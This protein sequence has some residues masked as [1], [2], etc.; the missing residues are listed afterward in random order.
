MQNL[1]RWTIFHE[2][3]V[4]GEY[5]T[6][7]FVLQEL[8]EKVIIHNSNPNTSFFNCTWYQKDLTPILL[9]DVPKEIR[10]LCLVLDIDAGM[11]P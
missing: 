11:G 5:D 9:A 10:A 2:N 8:P 3:Q 7:K 4:W 1:H 6:L